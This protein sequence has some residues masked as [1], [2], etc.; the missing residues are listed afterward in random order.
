MSDQNLF[1]YCDSPKIFVLAQMMICIKFAS[2][3]FSFSAGTKK[4][5]VTLKTIQFLVWHKIYKIFGPVQ[6]IL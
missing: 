4:F 5:G 3:K 1:R 2:K 6:I